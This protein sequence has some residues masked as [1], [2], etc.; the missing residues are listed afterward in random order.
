MEIINS[1]SSSFFT[2]PLNAA[3]TFL[4]SSLISSYKSYRQTSNQS[5]WTKH[6]FRGILSNQITLKWVLCSSSIT[7]CSQDKVFK[8][9]LQNWY[10]SANKC[11]ITPE[12]TK[13]AISEIKLDLPFIVLDLVNRFQMNSLRENIPYWRKSK[14]FVFFSANQGV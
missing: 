13:M 3:S 8:R 1:S 12:Q 11:E 14:Q 9:N 5:T 2:T 6:S 4:A 10:F 7:W